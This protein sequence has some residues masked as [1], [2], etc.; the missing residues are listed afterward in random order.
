ML[1]LS[2]RRTLLVAWNAGP[3]KRFKIEAQGVDG[4]LDC[5]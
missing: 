4:R 2:D 1:I 3:V 5:E